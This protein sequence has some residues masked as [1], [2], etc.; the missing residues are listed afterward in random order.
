[1]SGFPVSDEEIKRLRIK[2]LRAL[3]ASAYPS[4]A[5]GSVASNNDLTIGDAK[6]LVAEY[7]WPVASEM[8]RHA[9]ELE[10]K[11]PPPAVATVLRNGGGAAP[12]ASAP[13]SNGLELLLST[14]EQSR[15]ARTR[16]LGAKVRAELTE[17]GNILL[18]ERQE[19]EAAARLAV[20]QEKLRAEVAELEKE[21]A[22]KRAALKGPAKPKKAAAPKPVKH[23]P[24]AVRAWAAENGVTCN[25]HGRI[26]AEV[27]AAYD[28]AMSKAA[29]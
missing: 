28:T 23:S 10:G 12:D 18:E 9:L 26:S 2:V 21:L 15:N 1:M 27:Y 25:S 29:S 17:L 8:R 22:K 6:A 5:I 19:R 4:H 14:A 7:G 11:A 13:T 20:E 3:A 24:K 16:R